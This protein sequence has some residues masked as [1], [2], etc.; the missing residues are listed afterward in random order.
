VLGRDGRVHVA[1]EQP[2][3]GESAEALGL[4]D[5]GLLQQR[6]RAAAGTQEHEACPDHAVV[7]A[8]EAVLHRHEPGA[9]ALALQRGDLLAVLDAHAA[10]SQVA[11]QLVGQRAEVHVRA[12]GSERCRYA[13]GTAAVH[14][15]GS[16][17]RDLLAVL[18]E[19]HALEELVGLEG[20]VAGA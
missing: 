15:Q 8:V 7:V 20:V 5:P 13:P 2:R 9:V 17:L 3:D 1:Q 4:L 6:Q 16:P 11:Q 19:L 12:L 10:A 18:G 14:G